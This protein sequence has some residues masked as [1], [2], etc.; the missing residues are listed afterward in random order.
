MPSNNEPAR[1]RITLK[2]GHHKRIKA[3]HP[4]GYSNEVDRD[5]SVGQ[6]ERGSLVDVHG[7]GGAELGTA[8]WN[9]DT[10]IAL[11]ML[12]RRVGVA[13]DQPW[14]VGRLGR[15]LELRERLWKRPFYRWVHG[16]GDDLSGLV[17]D[18]YDDV[19]VAQLNAAG[20]ELLW[21]ELQSALI[22]LLDPRA[23]VVRTE[24]SARSQEG[25]ASG[26]TVRFGEIDAETVVVENDLDFSVDLLAGQKTGWFYD[27]AANRRLAADL[28]AGLVSRGQEVVA[29]DVCSY[30]GGF[31][32]SMAAAGAGSVWLVDRSE[33][34]LELAARSSERNGLS[35]QVR[36]IKGEAFQT[37]EE[38]GRLDQRFDVVV[39]DPPAFVKSRRQLAQG[40][41]GYRRLLRS[42]LPLVTDG[43][44]LMTF[45]CSHNVSAEQLLE[46][47]RGGLRGTGSTVSLL[48]S[49]SAG[50]DHPIH[51][52][53]AETGYLKGYL[54]NVASSHP[55]GGSGS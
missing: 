13:I 15:A 43:G 8:F 25:L 38:M 44:Y 2:P 14:L 19:L 22:E 28:V 32:L 20:W 11:R 31:G 9:P 5:G 16:E 48:T 4:W 34:A 6:I 49:L 40:L 45:S 23:I 54:L 47:V 12:E 27:Q 35:E 26:S 1:P 46:Q 50:I 51:P 39:L 33:R 30:L 52:F 53:V 41:R 10:L 17:I 55:G 36:L 21:P 7:S 3:G 37:L 42:A 24:A 18:R 29:L